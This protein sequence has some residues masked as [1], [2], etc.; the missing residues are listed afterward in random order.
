MS[1]F[2]YQKIYFNKRTSVWRSVSACLDDSGISE[3][4]AGS[5]LAS[6]CNLRTRPTVLRSREHSN[7]TARS[8]KRARDCLAVWR[9]PRVNG[10]FLVFSRSF[11]APFNPPP[12]YTGRKNR[13]SASMAANERKEP[14]RTEKRRVRLVGI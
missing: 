9:V 5:N 12:R 3:E 6:W 4:I 1:R 7:L 10:A 8:S 13:G 2:P 14:A 11:T